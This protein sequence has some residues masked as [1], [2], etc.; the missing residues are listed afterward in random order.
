MSSLSE[1]TLELKP[2]QR[3]DVIDVNQRAEAQ[4]GAGFFKKHRKTLYCSYHTTAGYL[5]QRVAERL[6]PRPG[7]VRGFLKPYQRLFPP[8]ADYFHDRLEHRDELS[9]EQRQTE[10]RN[11]DSHLT[12]I[13]SGLESCVTYRNHAPGAPA[14]FI[15]LDGVNTNGPGG[16]ERRR[17]RTTLIGFDQATRVAQVELEVPVSGHPI[18]SV[19]L[20][21]PSLGLYEQ[22]EDLI[23]HYGIK[24]GRLDLTLAEGEKHA[25]LT[26]NEDETLLMTHDLRDVLGDP[27][28]FM[29]RK[30]WNLGRLLFRNPGAL[31]PTAKRY[32]KYDLVQVVNKALDKTGLDGSLAERVI[33]RF[34][35]GP[36]ERR[37]RMKRAMSLFISDDEPTNGALPGGTAN[38]AGEECGGA[39]VREYGRENGHAENAPSPGR[40]YGR[41][42]Q[43][44]FQSPIL[45]QWRPSDTDTRRI[46]ATLSRFE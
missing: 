8:D 11:A 5:E 2:A 16:R 45:V 32:A 19:N 6:S 24:K 3:F 17:R 43:G 18:D 25:S 10:P 44:R 35:T 15:D 26:V 21:D 29:A 22:V 37:L 28:H 42:V 13:G 39:G 36:V 9:D 4:A 40:R 12:F 41:I 38:H 31:R 27:L 33:G 1:V 23:A 46:V 34:V 14:Y 20:K 7:Q 30:G